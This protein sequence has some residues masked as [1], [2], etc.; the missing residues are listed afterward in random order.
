LGNDVTAAETT[1]GLT[2]L[3]GAAFAGSDR[4]VQY[5]VEKGANID[6]K[7]FSGQTPL[8]K[9]S[10]IAP[11]GFTER[12]FFP[13]AYRKSTVELLLK[14]GATPVMEQLSDAGAA[15]AKAPVANQ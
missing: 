2:A 11:E 8:H 14:L 10:N 9:A 3:H 15:T 5:L 7:D 13:Y 1:T 12:N 4:I 6:A